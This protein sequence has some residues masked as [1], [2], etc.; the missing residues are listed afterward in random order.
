M[1]LFSIKRHN[2]SFRQSLAFFDALLKNHTY[3]YLHLKV[4]YF[5]RYS[6]HLPISI[7]QSGFSLPSG[8]YIDPLKNPIRFGCINIPT[9]L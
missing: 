2:F 1:G 4:L 7:S 9:C 5:P 3:E 8:E 6:T